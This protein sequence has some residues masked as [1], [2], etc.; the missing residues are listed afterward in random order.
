MT[1]LNEKLFEAVEENKIDKV[2]ELIEKGADIGARNN[3]GDT[4]LDLAGKRSK[5]VLREKGI[6]NN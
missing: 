2:L 6:I 5:G 4:P 3:V 1:N